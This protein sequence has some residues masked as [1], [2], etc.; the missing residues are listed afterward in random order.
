[1]KEE[2]QKDI[3]VKIRERQIENEVVATLR[4]EALEQFA[5]QKK[6]GIFAKLF[7]SSQI[8]LEKEHFI[9]QYLAKNLADRL[10]KALTDY[11]E[12]L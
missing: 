11:H 12:A 2:N 3:V 5:T 7:R 6:S 9:N 10:Q 8:E 4:T 1:M